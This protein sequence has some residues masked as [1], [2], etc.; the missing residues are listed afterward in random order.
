MAKISFKQDGKFY[1]GWWQVLVG[2]LLMTFAYVGFVS[3]IS[4]FVL[5]VTTEFVCDRSEFM[6]T[7]TILCLVSVFAAAFMGKK[8]AKG[9][10]KLI[11]LI[12]ALIAGVGYFGFSRATSLGQFYAFA[13]VLGV[14]FTC[15]TTM[16]ISILLNNWFGGKIKGTAMGLAF[17]GSGVGGMVL[18]PVINYVNT[19]FGWRTGYLVLAAIF[20]FFLAP[21]ILFLV[22]KSPAD[23][24]QTR[25]G[26][27]AAEASGAE[28]RGMTMAEAK[29]SPM[30]W[31]TS[32]A[33]FIA[34]VGSSGILANSVAFFVECDYSATVAASV[35]GLMLGSLTIGK[36]MVGMVCDKFG[37]KKG[38]ILSFST[39]SLCFF[40]LFLMPQAKMLIVLVILFYA[41][42]C[43][44]VTICPPLLTSYLFGEKD[45]GTIIGI[46]TMA[47]NIGGAFGG[48]VAAKIFDMTGSYTSFWLFSGVCIALAVILCLASFKLRAKYDY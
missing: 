31:L 14:P 8:M 18:T 43:A 2:F 20:I 25:L 41:F 7:S 19:E 21:L 34:V 15:L 6:L 11:M 16:P 9:N 46:F 17:L 13:A 37:V 4:V 47:T 32:L 30:L 24:G 27:T 44:A 36:P 45:Y 10:I 12:N 35:A 26:E 38:S 1:Y 39:F 48:T 22:V 28:L 40:S 29:K 23:K 33:I 3:V 5:P 42:G